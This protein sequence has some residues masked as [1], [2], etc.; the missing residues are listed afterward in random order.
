MVPVLSTTTSFQLSKS[1]AASIGNALFIQCIALPCS[2]CVLPL[3]I[4]PGAW[5]LQKAR[6][7]LS[8]SCDCLLALSSG[9]W[10][11]NSLKRWVLSQLHPPYLQCPLLFAAHFPIRI[12]CPF[13][14]FFFVLLFSTPVLLLSFR[15]FASD[16][17][18]AS[19]SVVVPARATFVSAV[20]HLSIELSIHQQTEGFIAFRY[21]FAAAVFIYWRLHPIPTSR[22]SPFFS[23]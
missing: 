22:P 12:S 18:S 15:G 8:I 7:W 9:T 14:S 1:Q 21:K 17:A 4:I 23:T 11:W 3:V 16:S 10:W 5:V 2:C 13:F 6:N 19:F 20:D